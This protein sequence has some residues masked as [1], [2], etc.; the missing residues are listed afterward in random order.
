VNYE[1]LWQERIDAAASN[2]ERATHEAVRAMDRVTCDANKN[3]IDA[4]REACDRE[5]A[6]L[7][8]YRRV[9]LEIHQLAVDPRT[10]EA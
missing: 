6:A 9:A 10:R 8:E 1:K 4:L 5:A 7:D 2:C 3:D